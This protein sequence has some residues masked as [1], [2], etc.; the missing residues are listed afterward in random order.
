MRKSGPNSW[1]LPDHSANPPPW[2]QNIENNFSSGFTSPN[3]HKIENICELI[4]MEVR[5]LY[6]TWDENVEKETIFTLCKIVSD[7]KNIWMHVL[8]YSKASIACGAHGS[9]GSGAFEKIF[10]HIFAF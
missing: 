8:P 6:L 2:I 10:F 4:E 1:S 3:V 5:I 9:I 7:E